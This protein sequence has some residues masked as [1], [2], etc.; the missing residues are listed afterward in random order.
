MPFPNLK[1]FLCDILIS[2]WDLGLTRDRYTV[3]ILRDRIRSR[4][5]WR[6]GGSHT[7]KRPLQ[8]LIDD[9][10]ERNA[11][12]AIA[13]LS[14]YFRRLGGPSGYTRGGRRAVNRALLYTRDRLKPSE[15][16]IGALGEGIAGYYLE[17]VEGLSFEIRPFDVSPDFIFRDPR[18]MAVILAEVKTSLMQ[19]PNVVPVA[20]SLLDILAKTKFIRKGKYMAYIIAVKII[21]LNNFELRRLKL[22]EI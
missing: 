8:D 17:D 5:M 21:D 15:S 3:K 9:F 16:D 18:T 11:A 13:N 14:D 7:I 22:E 20:I 19:M 4:I 2:T 6:Y 1:V 10:A 12:G